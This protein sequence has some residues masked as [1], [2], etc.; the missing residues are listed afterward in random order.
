MLLPALEAKI[1]GSNLF[2]I[3]ATMRPIVLVSMEP[4]VSPSRILPRYIGCWR[5][6]IRINPMGYAKFRRS[7]AT[8][9]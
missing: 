9:L 2:L 3:A 7:H 5:P 4:Q 6:K 1:D 8:V